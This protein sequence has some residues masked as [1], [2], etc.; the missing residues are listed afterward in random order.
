MLS[1][2]LPGG[3]PDH[4]PFKA[5]YNRIISM[6]R[7]TASFPRT[8]SNSAVQDDGDCCKKR[9]GKK[10]SADIRSMTYCGERILVQVHVYWVPKHLQ[11]STEILDYILAVLWIQKCIVWAIAS[12][13]LLV[14]GF[15]RLR[16]AIVFPNSEAVT[17]PGICYIRAYPLFYAFCF[18]IKK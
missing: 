10:G 1:Y 16:I 12:Y 3:Y 2:L 6:A 14:H 4:A 7:Y 18:K 13:V 5:I 8:T 11:E 15:N 17:G 9:Q